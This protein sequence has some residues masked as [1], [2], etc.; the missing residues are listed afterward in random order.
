LIDIVS[1]NEEEIEEARVDIKNNTELEKALS[2][3]RVRNNDLLAERNAALK[4]VKSFERKIG[5]K[6]SFYD[7]AIHHLAAYADKIKQLETILGDKIYIESQGSSLDNVVSGLK[8]LG[9]DTSSTSVS[10]MLELIN[11]I[12]E[13]EVE[14]SAL[15]DKQD[16]ERAVQY[17]QSV[18]EVKTIEE[19]IEF[20]RNSE[21]PEDVT[22]ETTKLLEE[23]AEQRRKSVRVYEAKRNEFSRRI[24][25]EFDSYAESVD[26]E[27]EQSQL[28]KQIRGEIGKSNIPIYILLQDKDDDYLLDIFFP[29]REASRSSLCGILLCDSILCEGVA[30]LLDEDTFNETEINI[31]PET[32]IQFYRLRLPKGK[33]S[34][35]KV[36]GIRSAMEDAVR[37]GYGNNGLQKLGIGLDVIFNNDIQQPIA[38]DSS[39]PSRTYSEELKGTTN[40]NKERRKDNAN[41]R[42]S[43]LRDIFMQSGRTELTKR[44]VDSRLRERV[45]FEFNP[46]NSVQD[47]NFLR[48]EGVI[49]RKGYAGGTRY[50]LANEGNEE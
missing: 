34:H 4:R 47:L 44:E 20:L 35:E 18:S 25:E 15:Y 7:M 30:R 28:K 21:L 16:L 27:N 41:K 26:I 29:T 31:E 40:P 32:E 3:L 37:R 23:K 17:T 33:Y 49:G 36:I 5:T 48:K 45:S 19:Q 22:E 13:S 2:G 43:A 42:I 14:T 10:K 24:K 46:S 9:I 50:F 39:E 12:R 11:K 38:V 6:N 8:S 1:E